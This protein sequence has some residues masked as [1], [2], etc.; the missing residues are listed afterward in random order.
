[1]SLRINVPRLNVRARVALGHMVRFGAV[2]L[3]AF[4]LASCAKN[5]KVQEMDNGNIAWKASQ[6][7]TDFNHMAQMAIADFWSSASITLA[8]K[9]YQEFEGFVVTQLEQSNTNASMKQ[10][11]FELPKDT[12]DL[13]LK[14]LLKVG[15]PD[16]KANTDAL[17]KAKKELKTSKAKVKELEGK[18]SQAS[19]KQKVDPKAVT[20]LRTQLKEEQ[21]AVKRAKA[22]KEKATKAAE[23]KQAAL[24]KLQAE[25]EQARLK[26][27]EVDSLRQ[28]QKIAR[29]IDIIDARASIASLSD[30]IFTIVDAENKEIGR[31]T[32]D[33]KKS[34]LDQRIFALTIILDKDATV[35]TAFL[36]AAYP[37]VVEEEADTTLELL[38]ALR[39]EVLEARQVAAKARSTRKTLKTKT[40]TP[41]LPKCRTFPVYLQ[42]AKKA[43]GECK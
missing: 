25:L 12:I 41:R 40:E 17:A 2:G 32:V 27:Q 1:M 11:S 20:D 16:P 26:G 37:I 13:K 36:R 18:L 39:L 42:K 19:A 3:T 14:E 43:A 10:V 4:G 29:N 28:G 9:P 34:D 7:P 15:G 38:Q 5:A 6:T 8:E 33:E 21:A 24:T 23:Q 30:V 35:G 31:V 22:A